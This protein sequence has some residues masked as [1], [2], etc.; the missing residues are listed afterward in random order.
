MLSDFRIVARS[1]R[2]GL[3]PFH[4]A[5]KSA[6]KKSSSKYLQLLGLEQLLVGSA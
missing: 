1:F 2:A 3:G 5:K 4:R 6:L